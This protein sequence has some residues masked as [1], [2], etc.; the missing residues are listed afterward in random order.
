M[1]TQ[2]G[3]HD[4][5]VREPLPASRIYPWRNTMRRIYHHS[6][7]GRRG[8]YKAYEDPAREPTG[9]TG[10][11]AYDGT[12]YQHAPVWAGLAH[13]GPNA[14]P[15]GPGYEAEGGMDD[16]DGD[17]IDEPLT[18]AQVATY[19]RIHADLS[20]HTGFTYVR[21]G[22]NRDFRLVEHREAAQTACPSGRYAPLWAALEEDDMT[23]EQLARL[24][25][26]EALLAGNGIAKDLSKPTELTFGEEAL[27]HAAERGWSAFLGIGLAQTA[28]NHE[29][30][31]GGGGGTHTHD[32]GPAK[33]G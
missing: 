19:R 21:D 30:A 4:F 32:V 14:N 22:T 6:L 33:P 1:I 2:D 29:H 11:V 23:P 18:A 24:E 8:S 15:H 10:T 12:L 13:G 9:W 26:V 7:E 5:A 28:A 27:K 16:G 3:F 20:A 31:A 17:G 25:R